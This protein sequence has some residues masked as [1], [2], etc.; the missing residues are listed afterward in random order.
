M[1]AGES[2][3]G[4]WLHRELRG[5]RKPRQPVQN[6]NQNPEVGVDQEI[7]V[8]GDAVVSHRKEYEKYKP[9][10]HERDGKPGRATQ[11]FDN[12]PGRNRDRDAHKDPKKQSNDAHFNNQ[13]S[14]SVFDLNASVRSVQYACDV[15]NSK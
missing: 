15:L 5:E 9:E 1:G 6:P 12:F 3:N 10:D 7:L 13:L 2:G 14:I 11:L 4:L 8:E